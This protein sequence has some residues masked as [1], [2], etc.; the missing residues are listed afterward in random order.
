MDTATLE[1]TTARDQ[2][3]R[4]PAVRLVPQDAWRQSLGS[5]ADLIHAAVDSDDP[6]DCVAAAARALGG[7]VGFA[8]SAGQTLGHT[9]RGPGGRRAAA[10]AA[11]GAAGG[12]T[13]PGWRMLPVVHAGARL[14]ILAVGPTR[15]R[16]P[17][18]TLIDLV[19]T[20]LGEQLKRSALV[21]AQIAALLRRLVGAPGLDAR[22]LRREAATLGLPLCEGYWPAI[23]VWDASRTP[24]AIVERIHREATRLADGALATTLA[25]RTVLL[26][27]SG[28]TAA[29]ARAWIAAVVERVRAAD[30][31]SGAYAILAE[32]SVELTMLAVEVARLDGLSGLGQRGDGASQ[33][34]SA[35]EYALDRLLQENVPAAAAKSFVEDR[36]GSLIAW[37]REHGS[38]LL[39]VLEAALDLPRH[40]Q[41]AQRCFMHRNTFRQR[42][43]LAVEV[44]GDPLEEPNA[45]LAVHVALKLRGA[46]VQPR[47]PGTRLAS[48]RETAAP[49]AAG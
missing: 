17:E 34:V 3:L 46:A 5:W 6:A 27:P 19:A 39:L 15:E 26:H 44:L 24:G 31:A 16:Q 40:D 36:L 42:L 4:D 13:P 12:V 47:R 30:A 25:R 29:A 38:D 18:E 28:A 11:A 41:A 14:G 35:R 1:A 33:V 2:P 43:K 7:P 8:G 49:P 48:M 37:D 21:H 9:P 45:R 22:R 20:L 32:H 10:I 23:L